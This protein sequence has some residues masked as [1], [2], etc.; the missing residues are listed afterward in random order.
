[1]ASKPVSHGRLDT[2]EIPQN[3]RIDHHF[4][5]SYAPGVRLVPAS[6]QIAADS[7]NFRNSDTDT[8][9]KLTHRDQI[10]L[11]RYQLCRLSHL[12]GHRSALASDH[13]KGKDDTKRELIND[14]AYRMLLK[15]S[16]NSNSQTR[17]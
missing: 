12:C 10:S 3:H 11:N 5:P 13:K 16:L 4:T 9:P 2:T 15:T 1:M 14:R 7:L 8:P 17:L 6:R